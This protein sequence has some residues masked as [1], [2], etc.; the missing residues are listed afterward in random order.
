MKV[1]DSEPREVKDGGLSGHIRKTP[2]EGT[3]KLTII[4]Q[5]TA[6]TNTFYP[7]KKWVDKVLAILNA[8]VTDIDLINQKRLFRKPYRR[9]H[10]WRI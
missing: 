8:L 6:E 3:T 1:T 2:G 10:Q 5:T 9:G 4:K 7:Y